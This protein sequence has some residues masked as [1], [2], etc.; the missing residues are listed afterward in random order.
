M[1]GLHA[2]PAA[3]ID[4]LAHSFYEVVPHQYRTYCSF[5][6]QI[7]QQVLV[8]FDVPCKRVPC[9]IWYT[10]PDHIYVIGFLGKD[11]PQK[12]DGHVVCCTDTL[13]IDAATHHFAKD[14][15][16]AVPSFVV[17][18]RF[19]FPTTALAQTHINAEDTLW[20][21]H[22]PEHADTT[23]P[24]EPQALV[25]E[26]TQALIHR[27][28]VPA[29]TSASIWPAVRELPE[30]TVCCVALFALAAASTSF[31][32]RST[33]DVLMVLSEVVAAVIDSVA[34]VTEAD[35]LV[36]ASSAALSVKVCALVLLIMPERLLASFTLRI[37]VVVFTLVVASSRLSVVESEAEES[38]PFA[39]TAIPSA[40]LTIAAKFESAAFCTL[41]TNRSAAST[42]TLAAARLVDSKL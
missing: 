37:F 20:W 41:L 27:L 26:Y 38:D 33:E 23:L 9:Q 30:R 39:V 24:T 15:G 5:T 18:P 19:T 14:F 11:T 31:E 40:P 13:L 36:R 12:W 2:T 16:L 29:T 7:I 1:S 32:D 21:H 3:L 22:P 17:T 25:R 42:S 8:H 4:K 28:S 34:D 35:A 6:S 10:Q